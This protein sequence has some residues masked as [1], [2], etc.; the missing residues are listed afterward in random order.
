MNRAGWIFWVVFTA[1]LP[2]RGATE[3]SP[4]LVYHLTNKLANFDSRKLSPEMRESYINELR[5]IRN[6][7]GMRFRYSG[8]FVD[9]MSLELGDT[10]YIEQLYAQWLKRSTFSKSAGL[11]PFREARN[12]DFVGMFIRHLRRDTPEDESWEERDLH[13]TLAVTILNQLRR[14]PHFNATTREWANSLTLS[15]IRPL[16]HEFWEHNKD[17]FE[18]KDYRAIYPPGMEPP[19]QT[20]RN[21]PAI[22]MQLKDR[23]VAKG[24]PAV[25]RRAATAPLESPPT[26]SDETAPARAKPRAITQ[27]SS[28][29]LLLLLVLATGGAIWFFLRRS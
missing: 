22:A 20:I 27:E 28:P 26:G 16:L 1:L 11:N 7:E 18:A 13:G 4:R 14:C 15:E 12:P 24:K 10:D 5:V 19:P 29:I 17:R 23:S 6:D 8:V 25:D 3:P 2:L 9:Y 21:V